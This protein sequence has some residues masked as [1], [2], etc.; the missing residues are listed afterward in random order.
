M[1]FSKTAS[2]RPNAAAATSNRPTAPA[3]N[4]QPAKVSAPKT[5]ADGKTKDVA[6]T[7]RDLKRKADEQLHSKDSPKRQRTETTTPPKK[8]DIKASAEAMMQANPHGISCLRNLLKRKKRGIV[9]RRLVNLLRSDN[10]SDHHLK[11]REISNILNK[12]INYVRKFYRMENKDTLMHLA[13]KKMVRTSILEN[14]CKAGFPLFVPNAAGERPDACSNDWQTRVI[15]QAIKDKRQQKLEEIS[16]LKYLCGDNSKIHPGRYTVSDL[17]LAFGSKNPSK[18]C[19]IPDRWEK[20]DK[21]DGLD[22]TLH[23]RLAIAEAMASSNTQ[24][25]EEVKGD[26]TANN[27][28]TANVGFVVSTKAHKQGGDHGRRFVTVPIAD[29]KYL[30]F[31]PLSSTKE[32]VAPHSERV[33]YKYLSNADNLAAILNYLKV[34]YGVDGGY[35]IYAVVLDIHSSRIMCEECES[36]TYQQGDRTERKKFISVLEKELEKQGYVLPKEKR[37]TPDILTPPSRRLH[38]VTR[39]SADY[40]FDFK[41]D[42]SQ[43][44]AGYEYPK[45]EDVEHFDRDVKKFHNSV[46]LHRRVSDKKGEIGAPFRKS[47]TYSALETKHGFLAMYRQTAFVNY[48]KDRAFECTER[49]EKDR[50]FTIQRAQ[51]TR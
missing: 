37:T 7:A 16:K 48:N 14:F 50:Q 20:L 38:F 1:L 2:P 30:T 26:A 8:E 28:V 36:V 44:A 19:E 24:K 10:F 31:R 13:L 4:Q 49:D 43:D 45:H 6:S 23:Q 12:E 21:E 27:F 9:T 40:K 11:M 47:A 32:D 41:Y 25:V 17:R 33:L 46:I 35:K 34:E 29:A 15:E 39:V 42:R 18:T 5:A 51:L 3:P 22:L